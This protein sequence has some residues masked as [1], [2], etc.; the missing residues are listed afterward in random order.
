MRWKLREKSAKKWKINKIKV[1]KKVTNDVTGSKNYHANM[2]TNF[3]KEDELER[4]HVC[5]LWN[6]VPDLLSRCIDALI[7]PAH[8]RVIL[9]NR[10]CSF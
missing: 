2:R 10:A 5:D 8:Q 4:G 3:S 1:R 7:V 6:Q 9:L